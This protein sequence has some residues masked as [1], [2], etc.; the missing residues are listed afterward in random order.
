MPKLTQSNRRPNRK[1]PGPSTAD[2]EEAVAAVFADYPDAVLILPEYLVR[3]AHQKIKARFPKVT[4]LEVER[5]IGVMLEREQ[6]WPFTI[7]GAMLEDESDAVVYK[8][9]SNC[10]LGN[11]IE[12]PG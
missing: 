1:H 11:V 12:F 10:H 5:A 8:L 4:R 2:F 3:Q 7:A 9:N 6:L